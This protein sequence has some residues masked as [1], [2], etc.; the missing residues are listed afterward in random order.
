M[1]FINEDKKLTALR[2]LP[3][4][5]HNDMF[6]TIEGIKG[7]LAKY[8]GEPLDDVL[9][10]KNGLPIGTKGLPVFYMVYR[11]DRSF[12]ILRDIFLLDETEEQN[13]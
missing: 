12:S 13:D 7:Q 1:K 11:D 5:T 4:V 3:L 10:E 6:G 9:C 8:E 2:Q